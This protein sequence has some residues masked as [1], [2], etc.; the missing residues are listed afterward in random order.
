MC[1]MS[2]CIFFRRKNL[3]S[4]DRTSDVRSLYCGIRQSQALEMKQK[5]PPASREESQKHT[6]ATWRVYGLVGAVA[7]ACYLNGLHGDFVHDDIPAVVLNKDVLAVNSLDDVFRNDFWGTPMADRV[8]HKSYRPLTILTFRL[9]C[10]KVYIFLPGILIRIESSWIIHEIPDILFLLLQPEF[11]Q[12]RTQVSFRLWH[13]SR[14]TLV[15][16]LPETSLTSIHLFC[17]LPMLCLEYSGYGSCPTP[18]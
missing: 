12:C 1:L 18:L 9:V 4:N 2:V 10:K 7:M 17:C 13:A 16:C 5:H 6:G 8:S 14:A 11:F 3:G 15:H